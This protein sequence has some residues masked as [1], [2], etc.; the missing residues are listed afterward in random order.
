[1]KPGPMTD[2]IE[3]LRAASF[4]CGS[5]CELSTNLVNGA[6]EALQQQT[7]RIKELE[8]KLSGAGGNQDL[9]EYWK[10]RAENANKAETEF[11]RH[12]A[13]L[14]AARNDYWQAWRNVMAERDTAKYEASRWQDIAKNKWSIDDLTRERDAIEAATIERCAQEAE[15]M[16]GRTRGPITIEVAQAIR[17]LAKPPEKEKD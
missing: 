5:L 12:I 4:G 13:E 9:W 8:A 11:R 17:A 14:E 1:M 15:R 10:Q 6:V 7:T 2:L 3:R 16:T